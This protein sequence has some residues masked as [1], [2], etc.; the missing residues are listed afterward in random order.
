MNSGPALGPAGAGNGVPQ[1][2][3]QALNRTD[4]P[5]IPS[6]PRFDFSEAPPQ[7]FLNRLPMAAYGISAPDG[8]IAWYN[9]EA[10]RIWARQPRIGDPDERFCGSYRLY[11]SDGTY[12]AHSDTPI[13]QVLK[14]GISIR[15]VDV[16]IERPD[17]S[18]ST[19]CVHLDAVRD[20]HGTIVGVTNFFY[21]VT[22]RKEKEE[23][24]KRQSRLLERANADLEQFAYAASHDLQEPIRTITAF[25]EFLASRHGEAFDAEAQRSLDFITTG[26]KRMGA[27][28]RDLLAYSQIAS[29]QGDAITEVSATEALKIAL[30]NLSEAI[31][32]SHAEIL[33][34]D[35]PVLPMR[36][37]ELQRLFQNLIGNAIKFRKDSEPPRI[38]VKAVREGSDWQFSVQDNGIGI[39]AEPTGK[40]FGLFKRLHNDAK[41]SGTGIGLAICQKIVERNGGRIW[42]ASDGPGAGSTFFFTLPA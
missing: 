25:S 10:A 16:I 29:D 19:V 1:T 42:V 36:E 22:E 17:G 41:Y 24:I 39:A 34:E 7:D 2:T 31:R 32:E 23:Q 14:D 5:P 33:Y 15:E 21:D 18:R 4:E 30:E 6:F 13:K 35:L 28:V 27:L 3:D 20:A 8:I 37:V 26:A 38:L 12:M 40:I 9:S 11:R